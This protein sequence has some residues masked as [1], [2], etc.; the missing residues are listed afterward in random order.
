MGMSRRV[1]HQDVCIARYNLAC[2]CVALIKGKLSTCC[3]AIMNDIA[4]LH[5][6]GFI[7]RFGFGSSC[8]ILSE[9]YGI[10]FG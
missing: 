9:I 8:G 3:I 10:G 7:C 2:R 1:L 6:I 5:C 4:H